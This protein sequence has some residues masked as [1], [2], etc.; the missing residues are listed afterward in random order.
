MLKVTIEGPVRAGKTALAD[1][2]VDSLRKAGYGVGTYKDDV[3]D[4]REP[5]PA[6]GVHVVVLSAEIPGGNDGRAVQ[7]IVREAR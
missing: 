1:I 3:S 2:L 7:V 4:P 5:G 6:R